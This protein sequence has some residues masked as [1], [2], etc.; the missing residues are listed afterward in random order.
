MRTTHFTGV[1]LLVLAGMGAGLVTAQ[2]GGLWLWGGFAL[3]LAVMSLVREWR[4]RD[5]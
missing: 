2:M 3:L 5:E 4:V 1:A